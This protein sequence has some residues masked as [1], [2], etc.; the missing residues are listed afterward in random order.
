MTTILESLGNDHSD[1]YDFYRFGGEQESRPKEVF[2]KHLIRKKLQERNFVELSCFN[3]AHRV[4]EYDPHM[5]GFQCLYDLLDDQQSKDILVKILAYRIL[6]HKKV[7]LPLNSTTFWEQMVQLEQLGDRKDAVDSRFNNWK[8]YRYRLG[9]M[10]FPIEL[11]YT[12][13]GIYIEFILKQYEYRMDQQVISVR[14]GDVVIDAGGGWG[15]T[16]LYFANA[17]GRLGRVH[18]FEFIPGNLKIMKRNIALNHSLEPLI[19]VVERPLWSE[20]GKKL[21]CVDKGPGSKVMLDDPG[22]SG[23]Q[24][25]TLSIDDWAKENGIRKVDFIKMDI[26]GAELHALKGAEQTIRTFRPS[27]AIALYH[28][29]EDFWEI[30][31]YLQSLALGYR[32]YLGHYTIHAEETVLFAT[33]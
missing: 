8:L 29:I 20:S 17:V 3:I 33:V 13:L 11:Y 24:I 26:E 14:E 2:W 16:A 15:D 19:N 27:L 23:G 21:F 9:S 22:D 28:R 10:G 18:S 7:K 5:A 12:A 25:A 31:E 30:P 6:G 4:N 32:Y 1:N